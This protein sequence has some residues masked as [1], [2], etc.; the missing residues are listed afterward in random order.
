MPGHDTAGLSTD[1]APGKYSKRRDARECANAK[2]ADSH[3]A[4]LHFCH[5]RDAGFQISRHFARQERYE[6]ATGLSNRRCFS[7]TRTHTLSVCW[8]PR[9]RK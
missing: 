5:Q 3:F 6:I 7:V 2:F 4:I 1:M 9:I 8:A